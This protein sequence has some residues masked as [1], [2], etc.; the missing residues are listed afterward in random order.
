M[1]SPTLGRMTDDGSRTRWLEWEAQVRAALD[2]LRREGG[3]DDVARH[4]EHLA[5]VAGHNAYCG[6]PHPFDVA[7]V[8]APR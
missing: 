4:L 7:G 3:H 6:T 1:R 2:A 5:N 8:G